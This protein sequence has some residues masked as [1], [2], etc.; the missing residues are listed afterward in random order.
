MSSLTLLDYFVLVFVLSLFFY[1]TVF[2]MGRAWYAGRLSAIRSA[3]NKT[4]RSGKC[5]KR[6]VDSD[7]KNDPRKM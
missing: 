3:F 6:K 2:F 7:T 4:K 5:Q 1:S